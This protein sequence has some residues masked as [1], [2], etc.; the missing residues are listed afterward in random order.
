MS[1]VVILGAISQRGQSRHGLN[2]WS[3]QYEPSA[4]HFR[5]DRRT[6]ARHHCL[7]TSHPAQA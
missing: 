7:R 1:I 5:G 3:Q 6:G 4:I 2:A